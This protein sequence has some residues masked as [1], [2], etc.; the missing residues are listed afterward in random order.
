[1]YG[2]FPAKNTVSTPYIPIN[3]WFWPTLHMLEMIDHHVCWKPNPKPWVSIGVKV[4]ERYAQCRY[5]PSALDLLCLKLHFSWSNKKASPYPNVH[6]TEFIS[7]ICALTHLH[8]FACISTCTC[9]LT[10]AD[11][12]T[13]THSHIHILTHIQIHTRKVIYTHTYY[14]MHIQVDLFT[15]EMLWAHNSS[16]PNSPAYSPPRM[17]VAPSAGEWG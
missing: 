10:G 3:V 7:P 17:P 12:H 6:Y 1:M 16:N 2:N 14:H 9:T 11:T 8:K 5:A 13:H 4:D 15:P